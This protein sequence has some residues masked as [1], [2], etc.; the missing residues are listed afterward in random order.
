M[1]NASQKGNQQRAQTGWMALV[2]WALV[3]GLG[4]TN[5]AA[6]SVEPY[7]TSGKMAQPIPFK[8]YELIGNWTRDGESYERGDCAF[9]VDDNGVPRNS[10]AIQV[11]E[12]PLNERAH[13]WIEFFDE[14]LSPLY[15]CGA[16]TMPTL[17]GDVL[18]FNFSLRMDAVVATYDMG[19]WIREIWMDGRR[20]PPM[21]HLF[22]QGHAIGW[23]EEEE[24]VVETTNFT[25]EPSGMDDHAH[26]ATSVMKRVTERYR[27]T[28]PD[29]MEV[30]ITLE[31]AMFLTEPYTYTHYW[32]RTDEPLDGHWDC[33]PNVAFR[34]VDFAYRE[35]YRD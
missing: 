9:L 4:V 7:F 10:C 27:L 16:N 24:F 20:H 12:L 28:G 29:Y 26:I 35:K 22:Y 18:K 2:C 14:R 21:S 11:D 5:L 6:Q 1:A 8:A 33:D 3:V 32:Q 25:F 30:E 34:E 15:A 19:N 13:A 23:W 17:L 31:D